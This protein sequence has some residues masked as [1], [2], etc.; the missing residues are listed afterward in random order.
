MY[1]I[2]NICFQH[3]ISNKS[4]STKFLIEEYYYKVDYKGE[5][6]NLARVCKEAQ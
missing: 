5:S 3:N 1:G 6:R 4:A 2:S